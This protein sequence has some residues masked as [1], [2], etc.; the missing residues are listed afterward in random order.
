MS[1]RSGN[2]S[3]KSIFSDFLHD[4]IIKK[5]CFN[6]PDGLNELG[7]LRKTSVP[8]RFPRQ[9]EQHYAVWDTGKIPMRRGRLDI[10]YMA[11]GVQSTTA[12]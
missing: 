10:H 12:S 6:I 9:G 5:K 8:S 1:R 11:H 2:G 3:E 4:S 7:R